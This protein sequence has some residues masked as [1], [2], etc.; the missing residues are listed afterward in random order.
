MPRSGAAYSGGRPAWRIRVR[1]R[2]KQRHL[3]CFVEIVRQGSLLKASESLSMSQSAASKTLRELEEL[4]GE[5]LL[6]R[7][8]GGISLTPAGE[9]FNRYASA[10]L[11]AL[12]EGCELIARNK[13]Q[14]QRTVLVGVLPTIAVRVMPQAVERF[15]AE[16]GDV[17]V[18][19]AAGSNRELMEKLRLG[20]VDFVVGR[21]AES[22]EMTGL[23][24]EPLYFERLTVVARP[25][26]PLG[27]SPFNEQAIA[28]LPTIV[29]PA[30]KTVIRAETD[31]FL[32]SL[33]LNHLP[34][35]IE[36]NSVEFARAFVLRTDAVWIVPYGI[37]EDDIVSGRLLELA[38]TS[39][40]MEGPVGI[41]TRT[42]SGVTRHAQ[43][44]MHL[45]R[46]ASAEL[47]DERKHVEIV[48]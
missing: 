47:Q 9:L 28:S 36:T 13:R 40:S 29:L 46:D 16:H 6:E 41:T 4:I 24:F 48:K 3:R 26:H 21:L 7:D 17:P 10:S 42:E 11:T 38:P 15:Q 18:V 31:R 33:G 5:R 20:E 1:E 23:S 43:Y 8:R 32:I 2:V 12:R 39:R 30:M 27:T 19:V 25:G 44:M 37:V 14:A 35:S 34:N 45:I 22:D